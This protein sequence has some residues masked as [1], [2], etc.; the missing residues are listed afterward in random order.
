VYSVTRTFR[1]PVGHRLSQ[2]SGLCKNIH[3]HNLKI[4]ISIKCETLNDNYMVLDFSELKNI[5]NRILQNW[6]HTLLLNI[7]DKTYYDT[8]KDM[9]RTYL[10][11]GEPTAEN[12]CFYLFKLVGVE[13]E[14]IFPALEVNFVRIW[15]S[16][17]AYAEYN[18]EV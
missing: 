17:D 9:T 1:V 7:T 10:V 5:V 16:D 3:G 8:L 13:L 12:L 11:D 2:H 14:T 18:G 6:D 15:E 4:Q